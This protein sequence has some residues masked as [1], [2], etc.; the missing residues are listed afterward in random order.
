MLLEHLTG[1]KQMN[2]LA[3]PNKLRKC[4]IRIQGK[5]AKEKFLFWGAFRLLAE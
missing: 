4:I 1:K 2:F 5:D 3:N